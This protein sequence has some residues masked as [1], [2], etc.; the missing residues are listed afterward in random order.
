MHFH[1]NIDTR[2]NVINRPSQEKVSQ[3]ALVGG[4]F[5]AFSV[6]R[7][8]MYESIESFLR[9]THQRVKLLFQKSQSFRIFATQPPTLERALVDRGGSVPVSSKRTRAP[10]FIR[11]HCTFPLC[12][13]RSPSFLYD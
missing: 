10:V 5:L 13:L 4:C 8:K 12:L 6:T 1:K 3:L 9:N 2:A 7:R 11:Q